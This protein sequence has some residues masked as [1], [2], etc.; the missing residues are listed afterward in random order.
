MVKERICSDSFRMPQTVLWIGELVIH[1]FILH[2]SW[3]IFC[4]QMLWFHA[5]QK[6]GIVHQWISE[7]AKKEAFTSLTTSEC[8]YLMLVLLRLLILS[9]VFE[10]LNIENLGMNSS[11]FSNRAYLISF[12]WGTHSQGRNSFLL[13]NSRLCFT[14]LIL[15]TV[16]SFLINSMTEGGGVLWGRVIGLDLF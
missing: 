11:I 3:S 14:I 13:R 15:V 4:K 7:F 2:Y 16:F 9:L 8:A 5:I 1:N 10:W 12:L 6:R